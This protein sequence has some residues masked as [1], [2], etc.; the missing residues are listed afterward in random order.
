MKAGK[1]IYNDKRLLI[2]YRLNNVI[3]WQVNGEW[4]VCPITVSEAV[5]TDWYVEK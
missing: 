2:G 3:E 4:V 5:A 1:V